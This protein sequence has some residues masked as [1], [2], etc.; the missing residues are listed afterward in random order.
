MDTKRT[1]KWLSA[2]I[3]ST[4]PWEH[5]F[6]SSLFP[7]VDTAVKT[8]II[9]QY[10][11]ERKTDRGAHIRLCIKG[12]ASTL[13]TILKPHLKEHII[14]YL[15]VYPSVRI[16][17]D[18][19]DHFPENYKWFPN[20]SIQFFSYE[21]NVNHFGGSVAQSIC[22]EQ[23]YYGSMA[24]LQ[25]VKDKKYDWTYD[26]A[27]VHAIQTHV[28]FAHAVG[29]S[30]SEVIQF[31]QFSYRKGLKKISQKGTHSNNPYQQESETLD[32]ERTYERAFEFQRVV[33]RRILDQ[34]W[35]DLDSNLE[36]LTDTMQDWH[37]HNQL[38]SQKLQQVQEMGQLE[39]T[40]EASS[41]VN[42]LWELYTTFIYKMNN[43]LGIA[44]R[45]ESFIS[46][47]IVKS[48]EALEERVEQKVRLRVQE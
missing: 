37:V 3:Y 39:L 40:N 6:H 35:T 47:I 23:F 48:L 31:F 44:E 36:G 26:D 9:S 22:E 15:E 10:F 41:A 14:N 45:D 4:A 16:D 38:I 25:I 24:V 46:F 11:F 28:V 1:E 32:I 20:N 30:L 34:L 33:M 12:E 42:P 5:F 17:P 13:D 21:P 43:R 27:M 19:P 29:L 18:Y 7:F 2:H 8:G